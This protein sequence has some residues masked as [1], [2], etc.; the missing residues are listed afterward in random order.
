MMIFLVCHQKRSKLYPTF[1]DKCYAAKRESVWGVTEMPF[2]INSY[3][4]RISP[5]FILCLP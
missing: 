2:A 1:N 3:I 4:T 5:Y